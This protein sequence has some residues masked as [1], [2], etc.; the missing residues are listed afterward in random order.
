MQ[1]SIG[2]GNYGGSAETTNTGC[3]ASA[4]GPMTAQEFRQ[5]I[6]RDTTHFEDLTNDSGFSSWNRNSTATA[7]M[8]HTHLTLDENNVPQDDNEKA[9][10]WEM[11]T[12]MYAVMADH[13]TTDKG[14][15]LVSQYE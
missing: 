6:K 13:L 8:L 1:S 2:A 9:V 15:S 5:A 3:I 10:F 11:Q 14:K 4:G 12:F 7:H